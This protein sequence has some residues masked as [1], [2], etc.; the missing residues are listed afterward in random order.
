MGLSIMPF[1]H[2]ADRR[3]HIP[4]MRLTVTNWRQ[5]EAGLRRRGSL[6]RSRQ[7]TLT[8]QPSWRY[9]SSWR[10]PRSGY[11][12][13]VHSFRQRSPLRWLL[14][15]RPALCMGRFVATL[16][17]EDAEWLTWI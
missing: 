7:K 15:E 12:E 5:Y 16:L 4:K 3:H 10:A 13:N 8:Q 11:P 1:K 6:T 9:S 2:N 17:E 14:Q